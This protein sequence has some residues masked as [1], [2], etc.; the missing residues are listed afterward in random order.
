MLHKLDQFHKTKSGYLV[1]ALVELGLGLAFVGLAI[2][3]GSLWLWATAIVLV[4][5]SA[6]NI[7]KLGVLLHGNKA[8]PAR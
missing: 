8:K 7:V 5:G 4:V 6:Q 2:D 1:F 3:R